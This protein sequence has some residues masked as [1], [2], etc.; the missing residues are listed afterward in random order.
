[1]NIECSGSRAHRAGKELWPLLQTR[2][3]L[4][5]LK[6]SWFPLHREITSRDDAEDDSRAKRTKV[7][8]LFCGILIKLNHYAELDGYFCR[9][10]GKQLPW[11]WRQTNKK[12]L[13]YCYLLIQIEWEF[14][15]W[16]RW[17]SQGTITCGIFSLW[18][19]KWARQIIAKVTGRGEVF[20]CLFAYV[21]CCCIFPNLWL[22]SLPPV[23]VSLFVHSLGVPMNWEVT[24]LKGTQEGCI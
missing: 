3:L 23:K 18:E 19:G 2:I 7:R 22:C 20:Y 10:L 24:P 4:T 21:V 1:M 8:P 17:C 11:D 16:V 13:G 12:T 5:G 15:G 9:G 6:C 14:A